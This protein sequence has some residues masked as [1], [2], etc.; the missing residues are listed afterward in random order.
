MDNKPI[1]DLKYIQNVAEHSPMSLS[2]I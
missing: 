1:R 2:Y